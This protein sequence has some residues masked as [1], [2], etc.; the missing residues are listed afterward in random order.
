MGQYPFRCAAIPDTKPFPN[1]PDI[2]RVD[3]WIT[4]ARA[5]VPKE[6]IANRQGA[7]R[8]IDAKRFLEFVHW[9]WSRKSSQVSY[10]PTAAAKIRETAAWFMREY[11]AASIPVVHDGFMDVLCRVSVSDAALSFSTTDGENV[12]VTDENVE[13]AAAFLT[14][15]CD[16]LELKP[17]RLAAEEGAMLTGG[18]FL[19]V[20]DRIEKDGRAIVNLLANH[21][22]E[23]MTAKE[24]AKALN[25]DG[26]EGAGWTEQIV[27][28][29][30]GDL[31]DEELIE[32]TRGKGVVLTPRGMAY[33]NLYR[34]MDELFRRKSGGTPEL[35][36]KDG[37]NKSG[38]TPGE[39]DGWAAGGSL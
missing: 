12:V 35:P 6:Q 19:A 39:I 26:G 29:R 36:P 37:R 13:R 17:Y 11:G 18:D 28:D 22:N 31:K 21:L 15:M 38:G 33:F 4:S 20:S 14:S 9:A 8:P 24:I 32:T 30:Y 16:A 7:E 34:T 2:S 23:S 27:V 3:I 25:G 10:T 5:D 1:G